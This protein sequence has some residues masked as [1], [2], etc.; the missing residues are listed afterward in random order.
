MDWA[1]SEGL[2]APEPAGEPET[3]WNGRAV[4]VLAWNLRALQRYEPR[5]L[6]AKVLL[7]RARDGLIRKLGDPMLGWGGL[8][9]SLEAREVPGDHHSLLAPPA[10]EAL[11][12]ELARALG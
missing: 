10:V 11:A 12:A 2:L 9:R 6:D 5:P 3:P 7:L 8:A 1:R 4:E